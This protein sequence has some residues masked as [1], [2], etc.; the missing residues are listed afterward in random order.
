ML[1]SKITFGEFV[2]KE[3]KAREI[4]VREMAKMVGVS[5]TYLSQVERNEYA[6]PTEERVRAIAQV[7]EC[8]PDELLALAGRVSADLAEII[9]RRPVE[10]SALLRAM[11]GLS[12]DDIVRLT[13]EAQKIREAQS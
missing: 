7:I 1:G 4:G 11:K 8:D 2:R 5:P 9:Q 13:R 6:P 3:R 12:R 10:I